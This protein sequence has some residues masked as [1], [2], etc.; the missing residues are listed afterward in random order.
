MAYDDWDDKDSLLEIRRSKLQSMQTE[1][2][3]WGAITGGVMTL[4]MC[5]ILF[6]VLL[7]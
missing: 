4:G 5:F 2:F 7:K 1:A 3:T 6:F